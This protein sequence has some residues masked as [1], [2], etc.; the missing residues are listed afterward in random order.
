VNRDFKVG[1]RYI[2][3]DDTRIFTVLMA[4]QH[5]DGWALTYRYETPDLY[6]VRA[7]QPE[8]Y[9]EIP[10]DVEVNFTQKTAVWVDKTDEKA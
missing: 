10:P 1:S 2:R 7:A 8:R 6:V 5:R 4:F 3:D 9:R